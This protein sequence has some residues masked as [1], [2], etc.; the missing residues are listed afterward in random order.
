MS[1]PRTILASLTFAALTAPALAQ[2]SIDATNKFSWSENCGWMNWRDAGNPQASQGV[3]IDPSGRVLSGFV[4][5]ENIGSINLG[6]GTPSNGLTYANT[7]GADFGLNINLNTGDLT[8][9][10][11]GENVGWINFSAG[12]MAGPLYAARLSIDAPRRVHGYA[13]GENIGW[14]NLDILEEGKYVSVAMG[15]ACDSIDYNTDGLF[16][17]TTDI[18]DFLTVFAGGTC[19]TGAC[20]DIDYNNDGLFP[21][22]TDINALL[23]VFSGGP[24]LR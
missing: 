14:I 10:A 18:D 6:D 17:D 15:D 11:W 22:I 1:T 3:T 2:S 16:P 24:C 12:A 8:G 23:S 21:D 13:W 19:S 5:A 4:W 20:G 9:L 7:T